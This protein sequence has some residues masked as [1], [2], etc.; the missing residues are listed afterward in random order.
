[1]FGIHSGDQD[2]ETVGI[3][4]PGLMASILIGVMDGDGVDPAQLDG[5]QDLTV[6]VG[7]PLRGTLGILR[8]MFTEIED[9]LAQDLVSLQAMA[10]KRHTP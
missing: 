5:D 10:V 9:L 7:Y 1:M 8:A 2:G 6:E 3:V 4:I